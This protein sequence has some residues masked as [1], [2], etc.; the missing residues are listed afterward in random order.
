MA[1]SNFP[2]IRRALEQA[3]E[4]ALLGI[5]GFTDIAFENVD[6]TPTIGTPWAQVIVR[7]VDRRAATLGVD[8]LFQYDGIV[9]VDVFVSEG[10][11][12]NYADEVA[13]ALI[14]AFNPREI[15]LVVGSTKVFLKTAYRNEGR[16]TQDGWYF[17]PVVIEWYCQE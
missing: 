11:G 1:T 6:F 17:V 9:T 8:G 15:I 16:S 4:T 14:N 13:D 2:N 12:P 7:P 3:V 10:N 5:S